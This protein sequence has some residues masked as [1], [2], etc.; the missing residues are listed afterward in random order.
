ME[1]ADFLS[2]LIVLFRSSTFSSASARTSRSRAEPSITKVD[3]DEIS[4]LFFLSDFSETWYVSTLFCE[5]LNM[6]FRENPSGG[7]RAVLCGETDEQTEKQ[8]GD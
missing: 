5:N 1:T 7:S 6:N 8:W 2:R 3:H 4:L